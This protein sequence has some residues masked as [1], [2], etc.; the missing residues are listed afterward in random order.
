MHTVRVVHFEWNEEKARTNQRKHGV[1]FADAVTV[2]TDEMA[3]TI[4]NERSD[5]EERFVTLGTD[6][7]GKILVVV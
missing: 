5:E 3:L 4:A 1:D 2:L 6:A 7:S